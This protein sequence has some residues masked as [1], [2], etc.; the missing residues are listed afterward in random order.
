MHW[1]TWI[2]PTHSSSHQGSQFFWFHIWSYSICRPFRCWSRCVVDWWGTRGFLPLQ[3]RVWSLGG[4]ALVSSQLGCPDCTINIHSMYP[5]Y[6]Y[7]P[8]QLHT[9]YT[10]DFNTD[11]TYTNHQILV[12][13]QDQ[14]HKSIHRESS[15]VW[16]WTSSFDP[17]SL[18]K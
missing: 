6:S 3:W 15:L 7:I 14:K 13:I 2:W 10:L 8:H 11:S 16:S 4:L 17:K 5:K 18:L 1:T 9:H 12:F